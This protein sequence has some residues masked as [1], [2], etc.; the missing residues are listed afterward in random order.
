MSVQEAFKARAFKAFAK[1]TRKGKRK[2][3]KKAEKEA[4]AEED[5]EAHDGAHQAEALQKPIQSLGGAVTWSAQCISLLQL[6][7]ITP[8]LATSM[9]SLW[10]QPTLCDNA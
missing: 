9:G 6:P 2:R 10:H 5:L 4:V 8:L 7:W 1:A 3:Q